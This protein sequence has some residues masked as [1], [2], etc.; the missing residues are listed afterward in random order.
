MKTV[1][2]LSRRVINNVS[3]IT[4][5]SLSTG[6]PRHAAA[7]ETPH[8]RKKEMF[9]RDKLCINVGTL[10]AS[11]HGKTTLSSAFTRVLSQ[12]HGVPF[13]DIGDIDHTKVEQ[14]NKHSKNTKNLYW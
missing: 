12:S 5:A 7:K 9:E 14:E 8:N 11:H 1:V 6:I 4:C 13:L 10:G 2:I 3:P